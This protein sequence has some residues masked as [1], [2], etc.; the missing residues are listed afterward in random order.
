MRKEL[1]EIWEFSK[2]QATPRAIAAWFV[3][4]SVYK[5][6]ALN[7][8][9]NIS[10]KSTSLNWGKLTPISPFRGSQ[11]SESTVPFSLPCMH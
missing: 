1:I 3:P 6:H 9:T 10:D 4:R 5:A 11:A 8:P 2:L 7:Y